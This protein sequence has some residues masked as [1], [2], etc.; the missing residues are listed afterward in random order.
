MA[1]AGT[2]AVMMVAALA[3]GGV[4]ADATPLPPASTVAPVPIAFPGGTQLGSVYYPN[5][6][7]A[8]LVA[9]LRSAVYRAASG[10]LDFYYQVTNNSPVPP[11]DEIHR[12]TGSSFAGF[13]TDV[14]WVVNGSAIACSA[15]AG[16]TFLDGTQA[17]LTADRSNGGG[18]GSVVGFNFPLGFEVDPGETSRVLL[19]RTNA[20]LFNSGFMSV[21]NSGTITRAAFQPTLVPEPAS[22]TLLGIGLLGT[23]AIIRRRQKA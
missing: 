16:G 22:L 8:D 11:A 6:G 14:Y 13:T 9:T 3:L 15:C 7:L 20:T 19:I 18:L 23:G 10:T 12:L 4:R 1:R 2:L 17:P 5:Q 21:I